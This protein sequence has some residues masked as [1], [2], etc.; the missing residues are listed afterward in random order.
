[1]RLNCFATKAQAV[2][3]AWAHQRQAQAQ[4]AHQLVN[5]SFPTELRKG[6]KALFAF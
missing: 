2:L 5:S 1:M 6:Q 3:W 4:L